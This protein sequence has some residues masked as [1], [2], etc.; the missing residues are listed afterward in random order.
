MD[1][2]ILSKIKRLAGGAPARVL[3]LFSGC[4]GLSLGFHAAG[5]RIDA[6]VELDP[7]AAASHARNFARHEPPEL[8]AHHARARDI[9][10]VE[11]EQLVAELGLGVAE[12][13]FDVI[14]GGPPCQAFARVG[15]AKLREVAEHPEA[16]K[17]DARASLYLRYL[18]YIQRLKPVA[19]MMENVPDILNFGGVNV[20]EEMC[21]VLDD[22]GYNARYTLI[23]SAFHGVPQMRERTFLIAYRKE[24]AVQVKFPEAT[25]W[26]ELPRGYEGTRQVALKNIDLSKES[27]YVPT[28]PGS[29]SLPAAVS[30]RQALGD[31]PVIT[32]HLD[33]TIKRGARRF[34]VVVP[35]RSDIE[36]SAY[37]R[38][39][40]S[41]VGF[42]NDVGV[43]DH[44]IRSLPR[45]YAIFRRMRP[46]DEYPAAFRHAETLFQ[47][48]I[49]RRAKHAKV[50]VGGTPEYEALRAAMVPPYPVESFPNRWWK[51]RA[52]G[53]V[54]TLMAHIGKDTYSH[55]H[56]DDAQA[57]VISVREAARLQSF[58]DGFVFEGTM[59][60]AFR[61]VGNAVPPLMAKRIAECISE[62]LS[63]ALAAM[64]PE[65]LAA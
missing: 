24:L 3:D 14:V 9:T 51:L 7:L 2:Q 13:A 49:A 15:R 31:L 62:G 26:I 21:G 46:G 61:Q 23:N 59:N 34:D 47:E 45:D 65:V 58:P 25:H 54:R 48:E 60:P 35:Y 33:G 50:L 11:P 55:I 10:Q 27:G 41:W 8:Y 1:K 64:R 36:P 42:E 16:F 28:D 52:D 6:A 43:A 56:Y 29:P 30:A 12:L 19:L 17:H 63:G 38:L 32:G 5:F 39:M 44:V 53:P 40:R 57:R 20:V 4:G 37:A 18:H 22:L